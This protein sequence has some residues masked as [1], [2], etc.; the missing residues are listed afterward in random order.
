MAQSRRPLEFGDC[1]EE[2]TDDHNTPCEDVLRNALMN[3]IG[4][5]SATRKVSGST[6]RISPSR[7]L[8]SNTTITAS[9]F[10]GTNPEALISDSDPSEAVCRR[11]GF[12]TIRHYNV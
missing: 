9:A 7:H 1:D 11:L 10:V 4:G 12:A 6:P 3:Q 2:M 5:L 8:A